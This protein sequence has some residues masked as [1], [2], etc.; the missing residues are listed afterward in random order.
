MNTQLKNSI[1]CCFVLVVGLFLST[2]MKE[3]T[4]SNAAHPAG[5]YTLVS[6]DGKPVPAS[7][8]HEGST[9]QVNSGTFT[10]NADGTCSSKMIFVSPAGTEAVQEVSATYTMSGSTLTIRW[11][12]AGMTI[13]TFEGNTFAMETEGITL[14]YRK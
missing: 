13:G 4:T 5:V 3:Q 2:C 1:I 7:V 8:S 10:I 14:V 12:D 11:T 6:V 9:L